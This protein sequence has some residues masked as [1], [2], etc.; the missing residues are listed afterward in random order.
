MLKPHTA[1]IGLAG[2]VACIAAA[3]LAFLGVELLSAPIE[4]ITRVFQRPQ[5]LVVL[6][7]TAILVLTVTVGSLLLGLT[8]ALILTRIRLPLMKFWWIAAT[9]PLA[10]PSFVAGL[11]WVTL[12]DLRGL[13]G[14]WVVLVLS[15]APY[16]TL[17][18]VAALRRSDP[19]LEDVAR[20]LG[21]GRFRA[22]CTA[23][24]P[25]VIPAAASGALL[26]ALYCVA[27]YGV[28]SIMR[29]QTLT[30][31]VQAA[32]SGSFN[33][34]LAIVLSA[35][36]AVFA[37]LI[38]GVE[39]VLRAPTQRFR[40][41]VATAPPVRSRFVTVSAIFWLAVVFGLSVGL[42]V[43]DILMRFTASLAEPHAEYLRM[44]TAAGVTLGLGLCAAFGALLLALPISILLSQ[45]STKLLRTLE[46]F[47][48]LGHGLPGIVVGLA[49][50]YM[51]LKFVPG[52]YQTLP[53]LVIAY[54][55]MFCAKAVGSTR[56]ALAQVPA[57]LHDAARSLGASPLSVWWR[58][59]AHLSWPG[60]AA[61]TLIVAVTVMKELP[62]TL[63]LRPIGVDTLATR[64]WQLNDINAYGAAA[65]Y[66]LMLIGVAAI[67][68][69]L[70]AQTPS[71]EG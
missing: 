36:L 14:S 21:Y 13:S 59:T 41:H 61:G 65:P 50:V 68:A 10:I 22:F 1:L 33:R 20:C 66:S 47:T 31:G 23:T 45:R 29:Y 70:L 25:Q 24:L 69:L 4:S 56:T 18:T 38:I 64:L 71:S 48:Y 57:S 55:L 5:T 58:V 67:P 26:V 51:A 7:N 54:S 60:I 27:E 39:R 43:V 9:L 12:T 62:A 53:L 35:I 3:P 40:I 34:S 52:L 2:V 37:L 28:V 15:T 44:L 11:S 6:S 32:F 42:P 63:M 19:S 46:T 49:M 17:P 16:I 30:I 8:T